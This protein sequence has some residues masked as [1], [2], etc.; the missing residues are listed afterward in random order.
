MKKGAAALGWAFV[1]S[2]ALLPEE[3][4][5]QTTGDLVGTVTDEAGDPIPGIRIA[6]EGARLPEP[7]RVVTEADGTFRVGGL[8]PG[9]Y[10]VVVWTDAG[11]VAILEAVQVDVDRIRRVHL[12]VSGSPGVPTVDVPE[13]VILG[14][15]P[16]VEQ[17]SGTGLV[18]EA[19]FHRALPWPREV[20]AAVALSAGA[21]DDGRGPTLR[22]ASSPENVWRV[23]GLDTTDVGRGLSTSTL[24][25][26]FVA[27]L[28]VRTGGYAAEYGG[29]GGG[30]VDV[31]TRSGGDTHRGE[32]FLHHAPGPLTAPRAGGPTSEAVLRAEVRPANATDFG[33]G[34]GGPLVADRAWF[35]VGLSPVSDA[36]VHVRDVHPVGGDGA[37]IADGNRSFREDRLRLAHLARVDARIDEAQDVTLTW[38][39]NPTRTEG[40]INPSLHGDE[41]AILGVRESGAGNLVGTW[42]G[43]F[44]G[45]RLLVDAHAGRHERQDAVLPPEGLASDVIGTRREYPYLPPDLASVPGCEPADP[46]DPATSPCAVTDYVSGPFM[47]QEDSRLSRLAAGT[48]VSH[49][50]E[51]GGLHVVSWGGEIHLDR[52]LYRR[53]APGGA[54]QRDFGPEAPVRYQRMYLGDFDEDG[55]FVPDPFLTTDARGVSTAFFVQD[56]F[57]PLPGL[58]VDAGLRWETQHLLHPEGGS[59]LSV[60][61]NLAPRVGAAWDFGGTGRSRVFAHWGRYHQRIPL[62]VIARSFAGGVTAAQ[63]LA[64]DET[65]LTPMVTG[66]EYIFVGDEP[67]WVQPGLGG[68][69]HDEIQA[70]VEYTVLPGLAVGATLVRR[71]LGRAI[72]DVAL[73]EGARRFAIA[74]PGDTHRIDAAEAQAQAALEGDDAA[75]AAAEESLAL[76]SALRAFPRPLRTYEALELTARTAP[77]PGYFLLASLTLSRLR[78]NY[79]GFYAPENDQLDPNVTSQFDLPDLLLN[80]YGPLRQDRPV[81]LKLDGY[82][83]FDFGLVA[84]ASLRYASGRPID[85]LGAHALYGRREVFILPRGAGGRTPPLWGV[86]LALGYDLPL[87]GGLTARLGVVVHNV[88]DFSRPLNVDDAYT[89]DVVR[90]VVGAGLSDIEDEG[91]EV[92]LRNVDGDVVTR[93]PGWGEPRGPFDL[94]AP[95][96]VRFSVRVDF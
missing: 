16:A 22:G 71:D 36:A 92:R 11:A 33:L 41:N 53:G 55:N 73:D 91:G 49:L 48:K 7:R 80:R 69:Y 88:F 20:E 17:G 87:T 76:L 52:Y 93:N 9:T 32:I 8:P 70:G 95:R 5:A 42:R 38:F 39:A 40:V 72:E 43:R 13:V 89:H 57:E 21:S 68:P 27:Q 96:R 83:R 46:G 4:R 86:D 31:V 34:F 65:N 26:E 18:L 10:R 25:P 24:P 63:L 51:L 58:T 74:N 84:G 62:N 37:S 50:F 64:G 78:G 2:F 79:P 35:Y 1:M 15:V 23:D 60:R 94:Q 77:R 85:A 81:Q 45:G 47:V 19:D 6:V 12:D 28:S 54:I 59:A 44:R 30:V 67:T 82:R 14:E 29:A 90:P 3:A 75:R 56:A 61:D 66:E